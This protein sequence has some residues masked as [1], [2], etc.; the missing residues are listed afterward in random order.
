MKR[1]INSKLHSLMKT[2]FIL[3][4]RLR[5]Y[6]HRLLRRTLQGSVRY[7]AKTSSSYPSPAGE[8][9]RCIAN[10]NIITTTSTSYRYSAIACYSLLIAYCLLTFFFISSCKVGK[11]YQRPTLEL[12]NQ[13]NNLSFSDTSSIADIEW[14]KFFTNPDLQKLISDGISYNHDLL[15]AMKR[16]DIAQQQLKAANLLQLPEVNLQATGQISRPSNN[17][18]NG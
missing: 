17:S 13:F 8:G 11:E 16:I 10:P 9:R 18:L 1:K 7:S 14:K 3:L 5:Y 6:Y 2:I 15:M 4:S 12:P